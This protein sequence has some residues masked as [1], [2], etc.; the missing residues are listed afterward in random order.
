MAVAANVTK[1][2]TVW[3]IIHVSGLFYSSYSVV[4]AV[5]L[6]AVALAV[7][8]TAAYGLLSYYSSAADLEITTVV[9]AVAATM[10]ASSSAFS[11]CSNGRSFTYTY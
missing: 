2:L 4:A 11:F 1:D 9:V 10:V 7:A 5:V 8:M 6:L 3:E